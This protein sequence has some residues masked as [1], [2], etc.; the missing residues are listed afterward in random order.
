LRSL[1][2]YLEVNSGDMQKGVM[3]IEPNVSVRP[4]GSLQFGTR[5]EIKNLNSFRALERSVGYEIQRQSD[6]LRDGGRV[7]QETLGWDESRGCTFTQ[8]IKEGEDDYRY[9]PEP[10]LPPLVVEQEWLDQIRASLPELPADKLERFLAQYGLGQYDASV[11]IAE[12]AVANYFEQAVRAAPGAPPKLLANWI[13][14]DL[15]GLLN[16]TGGSFEDLPASPQNLAGLVEMVMKGEI[17]QTTAKTA[18]AE[19]YTTGSTAEAIVA[20]RGLRQVSDVTA[21]QDWVQRVL[22]ENPDQVKTYLAGKITISRWLFG[23]VMRLAGGQANPQ[24]VQKELERQLQALR[25]SK[26]S[27]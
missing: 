4:A 19:M 20:R 22:T 18:L 5:T 3:R 15:F 25:P 2:R 14:G 26:N 7:S 12:P 21:I 17:N 11:L 8:R 10:D 6:V 16:Q 9:F 24:V 1:L 13:T 27:G 23:Q